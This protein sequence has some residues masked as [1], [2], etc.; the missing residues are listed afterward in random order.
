M[1]VEAVA[2]VFIRQQQPP[3]SQVMIHNPLDTSQEFRRVG[4]EVIL[5]K[6]KG[7]LDEAASA[8]A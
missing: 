5:D 4:E 1:I 2:D 3:S 7:I 6:I 8:A